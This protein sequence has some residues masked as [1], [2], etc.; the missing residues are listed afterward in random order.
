M[1]RM[2]ITSGTVVEVVS[3]NSTRNDAARIPSNR[4]RRPA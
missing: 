4:P 1:E 3:V 2:R